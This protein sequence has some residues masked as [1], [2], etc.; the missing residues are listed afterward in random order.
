MLGKEMD[1]YCTPLQDQFVYILINSMYVC[2]GHTIWN[3]VYTLI[4]CHC[5]KLTMYIC[6][7]I[8]NMNLWY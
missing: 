8:N 4:T 2:N 3:K 1:D 5:S 6:L 7:V